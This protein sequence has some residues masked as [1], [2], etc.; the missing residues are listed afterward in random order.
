MKHDLE[1]ETDSMSLVALRYGQHKNAYHAA[2]EDQKYLKEENLEVNI[3]S[4]AFR[5]FSNLKEVTI[6]DRNC[7]IGSRHLIKDFGAFKAADLLTCCGIDTVLSLL[8]ALSEACV[9]LSKLRIGPQQEFGMSQSTPI[10]CSIGDSS[11]SYPKR[12]CSK[13]ISTAFSDPETMTHAKKILQQLQTL[14][15]A[16]IKV[17]DDRSDLL[18]VAKAIKN[19]IDISR[20]LESVAVMK[21][22]PRKSSILMRPLSVE[23]LFSTET[24]RYKLSIVKLNDLEILNRLTVVNFIELHARSLKKVFLRHVDLRDVR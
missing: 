13:A 8:Q 16:G 21:I 7:K 12:L 3:L 5:K 10:F 18:K 9:Q 11:T 4:R 14:E 19:I 2:L 1:V 23:D 20:K 17:Q 6:D 22:G 24:S 15:I